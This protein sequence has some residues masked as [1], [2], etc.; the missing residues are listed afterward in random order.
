MNRYQGHANVE[1]A[2]APEEGRSGGGLFNANGQLIGVCYAADPQGN[3]GLYASLDSIYQKLDALQLTA[4]LQTPPG[5]ASQELA[6]QSPQLPVAAS[7]L[8]FAGRARRSPWPPLAAV[9]PIHF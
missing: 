4:T 5:G 9:R 2:R 8:K 7:R 1:A 3:E 6:S